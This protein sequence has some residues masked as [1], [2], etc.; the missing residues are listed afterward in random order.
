MNWR[1]L[2]YLELGST[3]DAMR[4]RLEAGEAVDGLVI[5]ADRQWGGRGQ[6][7]RDWLSP[8]GGSYQTAALRDDDLQLRRPYTA[9]AIAV[10]IAAALGELGAQ[11]MVKW[12]NDLYYQQRKV[13]G[14]LCEH[15][16]GHLLVGVG[17]NVDNPVPQGAAALR[18]VRLAAVHTQVLAGIAAAVASLRQKADI[19]AMVAPYDALAGK[20]VRLTVAGGL[21]AGVA[22]GI[23]AEGCLK[24]RTSQG[25]E[26]LCYADRRSPLV[27]IG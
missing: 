9:I 24:L 17:I 2:H 23:D 1:V 26:R 19:A 27:I 10:G 12:P 18:G 4:A 21:K 11:V 6:R 20:V 15:L 14:I 22:C 13:G 5:R 16:R 25:L 3:Q 7:A 8:L